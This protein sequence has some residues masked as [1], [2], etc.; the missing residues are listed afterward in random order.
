MRWWQA[1]LTISL[2]NLIVLAPM[3]LNA[4]AGTGYQ[5]CG[6]AITMHAVNHADSYAPAT[7]GEACLGWE[8][9]ASVGDTRSETSRPAAQLSSLGVKVQAFHPPRVHYSR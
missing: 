8:S 4:H 3:V 5:R 9:Q 6:S 7:S 1:V 2:G